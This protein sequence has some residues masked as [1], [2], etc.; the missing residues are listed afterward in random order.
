MSKQKIRE[1]LYEN[2]RNLFISKANVDFM[3]DIIHQ[4]TQDQSGWVSVDECKPKQGERVLLMIG[5]DNGQPYVVGYW[6]CG[7]WEACTVNVEAEKD[8]SGNIAC[9]ERAFESNDVTHWKQLPLP[10]TQEV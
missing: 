6:G 2:E 1:W 4:Y 3:A 7:E 5:N 10:P 9:V 8:Y